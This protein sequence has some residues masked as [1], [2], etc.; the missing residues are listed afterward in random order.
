MRETEWDYDDDDCPVIPDENERF[1]GR[2]SLEVVLRDF[3]KYEQLIAGL[4]E[5]G[6]NRLGGVTFGSDK[7]AEKTREARIA[8]VRAAKEKAAYLA[9]ELGQTLGRPLEVT[10]EGRRNYS[11]ISNV[12]PMVGMTPVPTIVGSSISAGELSTS[13]EVTVVFELVEAAE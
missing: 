4:F 12:D 1:V 7:N 3:D 6:A 13:A 11:A 8:A 2:T 9:A 5:H 10:E